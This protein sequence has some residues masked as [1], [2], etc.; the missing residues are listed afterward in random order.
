MPHLAEVRSYIRISHEAV[1]PCFPRRSFN[2]GFTRFFRCVSVIDSCVSRGNSS[3]PRGSPE[4]KSAS[5]LY[6][7]SQYS[8]EFPSQYTRVWL[9]FEK[10]G[11]EFH[12]F[13]DLIAFVSFPFSSFSFR[14]LSL[15]CSMFGNWIILLLEDRSKYYNFAE[16]FKS[17]DNGNSKHAI[18]H[19]INDS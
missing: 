12:S 17:R 9:E 19:C 5:A 4:V 16:C 13:S 2:R 6:A 1:F 14:V 10:C 15:E 3:S 11:L 7:H 8:M 18:F